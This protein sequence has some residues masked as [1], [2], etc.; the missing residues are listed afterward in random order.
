MAAVSQRISAMIFG[1]GGSITHLRLPDNEAVV[2][3][4]D[5]SNPIKICIWHHTTISNPQFTLNESM[6]TDGCDD[7]D[8]TITWTR[9]P[10]VIGP[11]YVNLPVA[12][13]VARVE[14][15]PSTKVR[16]MYEALANRQLPMGHSVPD[17]WED[18]TPE[19]TI[20]PDH[21]IPMRFMPQAFQQ[22]ASNVFE[23][24]SAETNKV[25]RLMRW[26]YSAEME[27]R[28]IAFPHFQWS[29][30]DKNWYPMPHRTEIKWGLGVTELPS[31]KK[32]VHEVNTLMATGVSE[33]FAHV[34]F[35]E[36][37]QQRHDNPRS[38]IVMGISAAE[39]GFK[40]FTSQTAP[41]TTWLVENL[42]SPPLLSM[43]WDY[44]PT[45]V[46]TLP[47]RP[48][49]L[50][51]P[52]DDKNRPSGVIAKAI[53]DGVGIRNKVVHAGGESLKGETVERI[54][55]GIADLLWLLDY[56]QGQDWAF[57]HVSATTVKEWSLP[58]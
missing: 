53:M 23:R 33:P 45:L 32:I 21:T 14:H 56:F 19:G 3:E 15:Q 39:V 24:L 2:F 5:D 25:V 44:L 26:R 55:N 41:V 52:R 57:A 50:Q 35:G 29:F 6:S 51:P 49:Q 8:T 16:A 11:T 9:T 4:V 30:G 10:A 54:L 46:N 34:L 12:L 7:P 38:A 17:G 43:V 18:L 58:T 48:I 36:A 1:I 28:P 42:P 37:W 13:C 20:R 40:R 31:A 22:D 27:Y 47:P